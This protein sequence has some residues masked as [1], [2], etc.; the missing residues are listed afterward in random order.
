MS[1][2]RQQQAMF[3]DFDTGPGEP[4]AILPAQLSGGTRWDADTS[5]PRA[6]M[7][8]VLDDAIRCIARRRRDGELQRRSL[9]AQA[10]AWMRRDSWEWPFSFVN[11]CSVLGLDADAVRSRLLIGAR[12]ARHA[13]STGIRRRA[14]RARPMPKRTIAPRVR[15]SARIT[16]GAPTRP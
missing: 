1:T 10:E 14:T 5:G 6:L 4:L 7:L 2:R 9:A 12:R 11:I 16:I 13:G 3:R 8:A 15:T